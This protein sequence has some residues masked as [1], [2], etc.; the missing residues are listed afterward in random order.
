MLANALLR[1][2]WASCQLDSLARCRHEAATEEALS[3]LPLN[4]NETYRRR[5]ASILTEIKN[6]AI[7][8]LQFP[9]HSKR[10]LKL[11]EAKEVIATQIE[12]ESQDLTTQS[13]R[14]NLQE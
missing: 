4:L 12:N 13:P 14:H 3:S 5:I 6:D 7:L 8:L 1:L 2:R 10:P 9:V 11:A